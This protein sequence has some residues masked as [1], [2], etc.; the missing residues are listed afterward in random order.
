LTTPS[1]EELFI[2]INIKKYTLNLMLKIR[3]LKFY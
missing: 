1:G 3:V 2:V